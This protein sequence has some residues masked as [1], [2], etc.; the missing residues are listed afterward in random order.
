MYNT[1]TTVL[2]HDINSFTVGVYQSC[3]DSQSTVNVYEDNAMVREIY[4]WHCYMYR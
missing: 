4:Q 3:A 1:N 2:N